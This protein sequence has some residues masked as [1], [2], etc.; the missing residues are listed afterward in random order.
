MLKIDNPSKWFH[1]QLGLN[2]LERSLKCQMGRPG[3]SWQRGYIFIHKLFHILL[4]LGI[5]IINL[6]NICWRAILLRFWSSRLGTGRG[7]RPRLRFTSAHRSWPRT[8]G[9]RSALAFAPTFTRAT[10]GRLP[11]SGP[12]TR[13]GLLGAGTTVMGARSRT[14][15]TAASPSWAGPRPR[16]ASWVWAG[17]ASTFPGSIFNQSDSP[18]IDFCII[19]FI[20]S[21]FHIRISSKFHNTSHGRPFIFAILVGISI[22]YF[23]S[24]PHVVLEILPAHSGG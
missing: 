10:A 3:S 15:A 21:I 12:R 11:T 20:Q 23:S 19:Q 9:T 22:G 18:A 4:F 5:F 16:P 2:F 24:L 8:I 17:T 7:W 1:Y 6:I 14:A 13:S